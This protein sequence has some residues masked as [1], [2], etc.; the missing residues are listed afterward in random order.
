MKKMN[1]LFPIRWAWL[2][3]S[4]T[5]LWLI[6]HPTVG[7]LCGIKNIKTIYSH[8]AIAQFYL[9]QDLNSTNKSDW[10]QAAQKLKEQKSVL[11]SYVMDEVYD[12]M[13]GEEAAIAPYYAG[14]YLSMAE[15][16]ENLKFVY[17]KEGTNIFVDSICVPKNAQNVDA[18]MLYINFLL[19]AEIAR[20]NAE[21]ICYATPNAAVMEMDT[22]SLKDKFENFILV[23]CRLKA[24]AL[25]DI[26]HFETFERIKNYY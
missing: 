8:F 23:F 6:K 26:G 11:Q 24:D 18:A 9:G 16:N 17:P 13:E 19:E 14:D 12:K 5:K 10:D 2:D 4:I 1:I 22:Y 3:S 21:Y 15:N 7:V 20:Q 25:A